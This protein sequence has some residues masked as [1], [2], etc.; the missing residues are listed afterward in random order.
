MHTPTR[1]DILKLG[2]SAAASA[3]FVPGVEPRFAAWKKIP[4]G[5][6]LW[7]VRKQLA[8]EIPGTLSEL[9]RIGFDAVELENAFGKSGA[10]WRTY[11]DAGKLKPCGFHHL[12]EEL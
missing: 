9:S 12:L 3:L 1:R 11:L 5:T 4:I 7:C 8:T 6:Q 10:E 2:A